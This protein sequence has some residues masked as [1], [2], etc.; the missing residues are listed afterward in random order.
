MKLKLFLFCSV[1][2]GC[3]TASS[4]VAQDQLVKRLKTHVQALTADGLK[5]RKAGTEGEELAAAYVADCLQKSGVQLL[6]PEYGQEFAILQTGDTLFSRNIVGIIEGHDPQLREEF[7]VIGANL[8]HLG[9]HVLTRNGKPETQLYPGADANASGLAVLLELADQLEKCSFLLR[10]SVILVAFGAS[11]QAQAGSWYFVNRA[12]PEIEQV[13]IMV[14][15]Q[16]VGRPASGYRY[17]YFTGGPQ[18]EVADLIQQ[19]GNESGYPAPAWNETMSLSSDYLAFYQRELPTVLFTSGRS[20]EAG[21]V[22]DVAS[23]LDYEAMET[24]CGYVLNFVLEA[25]RRDE[26][27]EWQPGIQMVPET[28]GESGAAVYGPRDVDRAPEFFHGDERRFLDQWVYGYLRYPDYPMS[29]GIQGTVMVS[30]IVE[31]DGAVTNVQV[32]RGV[33]EALDNEAVRVVSASPK[34]K[35]GQM[36]GRKVRV[37]YTIPIEFRLEKR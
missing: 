24:L 6:C 10:R 14:D 25:A 29:Q 28:S 27:I 4:L 20:M 5:G 35:P 18:K 32:V 36:S 7:V 37:K 17:Y 23:S 8:D 12:F 2:L 30:F 13:S 31:P 21:T 34:W 26:K 11:Q 22:R 19:V 3:A 15:L 33:H 1:L 16:Q 9:T